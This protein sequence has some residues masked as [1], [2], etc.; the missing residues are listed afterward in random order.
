MVDFVNV[1]PFSSG[2]IFTGKKTLSV[3]SFVALDKN[4]SWWLSYPFEK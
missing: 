2:L 4:A 1:N 3:V